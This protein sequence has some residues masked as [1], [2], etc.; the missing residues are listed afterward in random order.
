MQSTRVEKPPEP[1]PQDR[2]KEAVN[3]EAGRIARRKDRNN[4]NRPK[5]THKCDFCAAEIAFPTSVSTATS[6]AATI[7]QTRQLRCTPMI[8]LDRRKPYIKTCTPMIKLDRRR[9][10]IK[11]CTPM[12]K[13]DG[14]RP[15]IKTCT[16]MI[17]LVRRRPYIKTCTHIILTP[18]QLVLLFTE[19][20]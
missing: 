5:T 4:S 19:Q 9:P 2:G 13:L 16:P 17:K 12:I 15:Y 11:T 14:R 8:K 20:L 1:T 7:K 6:D 10:Y 3:A 18:G